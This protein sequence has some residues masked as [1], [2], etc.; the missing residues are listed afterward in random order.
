[1]LRNCLKKL[2]NYRTRCTIKTLHTPVYRMKNL[3]VLRD[4]LSGIKLLDKIIS[5]SSYNKTLIYEPKYKSRPQVVSSQDTMRLQNVLREFLDSLQIDEATNTELQ[6]DSSRKLGKVG[7]QL[8]LDCTRDNLTLNSTSLTSSLLEYYFKYPKKE[9]VSGIKIGLRYIRGFLEQNKI[10]V[11]GQNDIDALVDQFTMSSLDSQSVKNVLRAVNYQLFSDD[12]VRVINGN[13]TYDEIDV[14][15]GWKYPAGILD[16]NEAYLRSLEL[17]NKKLVSVDK[18]M[19]VL[20]YDGTLRDANKI[21]PTITYARNLKKFVLLIVKGDCT[22]DALTSITINNNRNK[23]ENN[24]SRTIIMKYSNKANK[25]LALQE[26]H[27]FVKFLRLP[28]GYDSIYSPEYSTLVPSKM[29]ADKYYG[30]V[31]SMKATTG[32]AFL[33]NSIDFESSQ[34][35][36]SQ[37]FLQQTVT[38]K[39]GG[40]NEIEID[41]RRNTL[42][43]FLNNSLCHGLAKGFIPSHG[44]SLLKAVPGLSRL[45]ANEPDFMT[46]LGIDAVLS[47][48][49]LPSEVAFK[50]AYGYNH[51]EISNLIAEAIN[52]NSFQLAKFSSTSKLVDT[53]KAG[54]IEPWNKMDSCLANIAT[55]IKLLTSCNTIVTCIYEKPEKR[56]A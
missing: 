17:P 33:Y 3:Q 31:E 47:A 44:I 43:N 15:K 8:F 29:C 35:E 7:L 27:D 25:N 13:K 40:H 49:V 48:V 36:A 37:S 22:G 14:S 53:T 2:G 39:I 12:I 42:E 34:N 32:E 20:V 50:N 45:K 4:I 23:R 52:E 54:S 16:T 11:K 56:T 41:Q 38:L 28:C 18:K 26:N 1:M 10:M 30:S 21:L 24:E 19:L 51:H 6:L 46:K 55:F 9:V 5:S